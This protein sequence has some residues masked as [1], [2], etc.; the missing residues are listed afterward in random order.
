SSPKLAP[1]RAAPPEPV[2]EG[3]RRRHLAGHAGG[4]AWRSG[5][6]AGSARCGVRLGSGTGVAPD[7]A[8]ERAGLAAEN[9]ANGRGVGDRLAR[10]RVGARY[11]WKARGR[12]RLPA[13]L[14]RRVA[15]DFTAGS[16]RRDPQAFRTHRAS[17]PSAC[18]STARRLRA[19]FFLFPSGLGAAMAAVNRRNAKKKAPKRAARSE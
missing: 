2:R 6:G 9:V 3:V 12:W 13:V 15:C 1:S 10:A 18:L 16:V 7:T 14:G 4:A 19:R 8:G 5:G 11:G 17:S